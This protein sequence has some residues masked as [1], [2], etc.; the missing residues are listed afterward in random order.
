[1]DSTKAIQLNDEQHEFHFGLA[2][3]YYKQGKLILA[4][5]AMKKAAVLTRE[6]HTK[7]QYIAKLNFLR[8]QEPSHH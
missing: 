6:R 8:Y 4:K 3:T 7:K 2:K 5:K 1:M